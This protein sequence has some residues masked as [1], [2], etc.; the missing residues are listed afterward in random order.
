MVEINT[1]Q[2]LQLII[3]PLEIEMGPFTVVPP[4]RWLELFR[5]QG[6]TALGR[7]I[8]R[9]HRQVGIAAVFI[10]EPDSPLSAELRPNSPFSPIPN[11]PSSSRSSTP[12]YSPATPTSPP[13]SQQLVQT[14]R[15]PLR[16]KVKCENVRAMRNA[17]Q[18]Q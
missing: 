15:G 2:A 17:D 9:N 4:T 3:V 7:N 1:L 6:T 10:P 13:L 14:T 12:Y 16:I 18:Q 8:N 11:T 5:A